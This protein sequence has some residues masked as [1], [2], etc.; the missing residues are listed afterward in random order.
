VNLCTIY[1][2]HSEIYSETEFKKL[3]TVKTNSIQD[4]K[5]TKAADARIK[6]KPGKSQGANRRKFI[7]QNAK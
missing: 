6:G 3:T 4:E 1:N 7:S 2:T 5:L